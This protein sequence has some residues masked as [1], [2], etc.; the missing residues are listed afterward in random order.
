MNKEKLTK[1]NMKPSLSKVFLEL[2]ANQKKQKS[3]KT[4]GKATV[5]ALKKATKSL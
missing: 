4:Y 3:K 2:A 1:S 5:E